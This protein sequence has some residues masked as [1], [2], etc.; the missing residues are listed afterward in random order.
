M[1]KYKINN[2]TISEA[3]THIKNEEYVLPDFQRK[4]VWDEKRIIKLFDSLMRDY[5]Y[6]TLVFWLINDK[7][8]NTSFTFYK[9][10]NHFNYNEHKE[11]DG[12]ETIKYSDGSLSIVLD[13]QQRLTSFNIGVR[14]YIETH[15]KKYKHNEFIEIK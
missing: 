5:P 3:I 9:F 1:N 13:G 7:N 15:K 2:I 8:K 12:D 11:I 10:I 4:F 14:G 6:G